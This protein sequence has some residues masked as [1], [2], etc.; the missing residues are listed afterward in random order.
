LARSVLKQQTQR[1]LRKDKISGRLNR[2]GF[3]A[4]NSH[5]ITTTKLADYAVTDVKIASG[6]SKSKVG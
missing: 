5:R 2:H 3:T 1:A 6:I 4:A